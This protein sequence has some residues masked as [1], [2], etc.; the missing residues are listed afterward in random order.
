MI[1]D[2]ADMMKM[3]RPRI[4]QTLIL[5]LTLAA[6]LGSSYCLAADD[7]LVFAVFG[8]T[9]PGPKYER[10]DITRQLVQSMVQHDP[11]FVIGTGDY[12]EGSTDPQVVRRQYYRFFEALMPLKT[13]GDIPVAFSTGN[14]DIRGS[15]AN[16]RIF[17]EY[18]HSRRYCFD[19]G[20]CHFIILDSEIPGQQ[21]AIKGEQWQWLIGDLEQAKDADFIF[22]TLHRPLFP[23]DG[24]RG[25]SMDVDIPLRD[26]LHAL[27]VKHKVSAVFVGHEHL[28]NYSRRDGIDYFITGGGGAPLYAK[29]EDGGFYHYLLVTVK[30][31]SYKVAVYSLEGRN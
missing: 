3:N 9:R 20:N 13:F 29:P 22:V 15:A 27:F 11:A 30:D 2:G 26:R 17:E 31:G 19:R 24:H 8:D 12:I 4:A 1:E 16:A 25:S 21:G 18:F 10:L 5:L 6:V 23:V 7:E 28:Y 14:H